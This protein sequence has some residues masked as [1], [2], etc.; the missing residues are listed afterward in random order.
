VSAEMMWPVVGFSDV[1]WWD[2]WLMQMC[3]NGH[4]LVPVYVYSTYFS[5]Y[6]TFAL[7]CLFIFL[8]AMQKIMLT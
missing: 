6:Q 5:A 3:L 4:M 7:F 1:S 2:Q 8:G